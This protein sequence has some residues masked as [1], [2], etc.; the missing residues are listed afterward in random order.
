MMKIRT[1]I[2]EDAAG[3]TKVHVASW[4][5][6]YKDI[7]PEEFLKNISFEHRLQSWSKALDKPPSEHGIFVAVSDQEEITGFATGGSNRSTDKFPQFEGELYAIYLLYSAWGKGV[8]EQL[9]K[10]VVKK[11][12]QDNI[13][14]MLIWVL[15]DNPAC[16]FYE[17]MGG[18]IVGK[19]EIQIAG[20]NYEELAYGWNNLQNLIK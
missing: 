10:S 7:L 1:A 8:G 9:T 2:K 18:I 3:I 13:N 14:S 11:L 16:G 5:A 4:Q 12:G 19:S 6:A 17:K 20:G 15:A